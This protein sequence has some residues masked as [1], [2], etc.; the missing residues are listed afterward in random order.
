MSTV[1]LVPTA[2][3]PVCGGTE[4]EPSDQMSRG[5][6][7]Y[8]KH[9]AGPLGLSV[10][11]LINRAQVYR[12]SSCR[13]VFCDPWLS[14]ELASSLF[15]AGS[16]E[17]QAGWTEVES[18]LRNIEGRFGVRNH[19]LYAAV[20]RRTGV[21]RS[22][23]E[24]GC[25][26]QGFLI[27]M[28]ARESDRGAR[29]RSFAKALRRDTD[30]RWSRLT[31]VYNFLEGLSR[32]FLVSALRIQALVDGLARR[33]QAFTASEPTSPLPEHRYLL[34][35]DTTKGWGSNCVRYGAT[36]QYFAHTLLDASVIPVEEARRGQTPRFDLVGVFNSL[37]HTTFPLDVLRT[38]LDMTGHVLLVT[39]RAGLAG[40]QHL[41]A[42]DDDFAAWLGQSFEGVSVEDLRD[43]VETGARRDYSYLLLTRRAVTT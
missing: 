31:R 21:L 16:P 12:C 26:F 24:F 10:E 35:Q 22:Y 15:C 14:T 19:R 13:S 40:K 43:E 34:T 42:F 25:P 1:A 4:R 2:T 33:E 30:K 36:C 18:W 17:H 11:E 38:L 7:Q 3:C 37:D 29:V 41:Y 23:A 28:R 27:Q 9:A 20:T 8:L 6:T 39:H 5:G 32:R